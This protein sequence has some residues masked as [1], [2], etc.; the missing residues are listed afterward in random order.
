MAGRPSTY[1][2]EV[3]AELCSRL[4]EGKSLRSVCKA[5]DMPSVP[6]VFKWI[7]D[8]PAFLK[9]YEV[10]KAESADAMVDEMLDIADDGTNDWMERLGEDG[11][12]IGYVLN[13][14]H[15][16]RSRLRLDA[17]KW[18][19]SKLKPKKYG[20]KVGL[21]MSGKDGG[22]IETVAKVS[23]EISAPPKD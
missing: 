16:Q 10:A 11:Q 22:P 3:A 13:G 9:Q 8:F 6:T 19:A 23:V 5:D 2:E 21:E 15:V 7:R 12:P 20:E 18:I 14:E 17:R 4:A 1:S